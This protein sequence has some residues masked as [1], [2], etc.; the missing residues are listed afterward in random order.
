MRNAYDIGLKQLS[1]FNLATSF[2]NNPVIVGLGL[3][4]TVK[5][6]TVDLVSVFTADWRHSSAKAGLENILLMAWN[7]TL[8]PAVAWT[9]V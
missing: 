6:L 1:L 5:S 2:C 4:R 9:L 8:L 3:R 7:F